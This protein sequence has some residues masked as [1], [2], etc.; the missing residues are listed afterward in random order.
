MSEQGDR[1]NGWNEWSRFVLEALKRLEKCYESLDER[2]RTLEETVSQIPEIKLDVKEV[3]SALALLLIDMTV[4]KT[5]S[6]M[7]GGVSGIV[8]GAITSL[9]IIAIAHSMGWR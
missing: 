3:K 6:A 5:K 7:W 2:M 8:A 9:L 1:L 4:L